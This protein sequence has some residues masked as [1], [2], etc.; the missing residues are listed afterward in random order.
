MRSSLARGVV[1]WST[2]GNAVLVFLGIL[3][4]A[5][6]YYDGNRLSLYAGLVVIVAGTLFAVLRIV[7]GGRA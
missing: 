3:L 4:L 6:G 2:L 1:P 5:F 7:R